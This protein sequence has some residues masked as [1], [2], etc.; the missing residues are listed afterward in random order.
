ML[1]LQ[2]QNTLKE[3]GVSRRMLAEHMYGWT[4][5]IAIW[6]TLFPTTSLQDVVMSLSVHRQQKI[7]AGGARMPPS[8]IFATLSTALQQFH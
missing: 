6:M 4:K 2:L 7:S 1:L 5:L 3:E 8:A